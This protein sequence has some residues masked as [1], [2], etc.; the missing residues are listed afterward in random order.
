MD[1]VDNNEGGD[2]CERD[3]F[4]APRRSKREKSKS[5]ARV[6]VEKSAL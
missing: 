5:S 4:P 3:P 1:G 6:F 2:E